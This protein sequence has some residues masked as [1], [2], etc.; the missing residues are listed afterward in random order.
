MFESPFKKLAVIM[1]REPVP[2]KVKTRLSPPLSHQEAAELYRCFLQDRLLAL[3]ALKDAD[4][5]VAY[6]PSSARKDVSDFC[7]EGFSLF[8][9]NGR[10]LGEKMCHIFREKLSEGYAAVSVTGSDSP[11]LPNRLIQASFDLLLVKGADLVLGPAPDGGYYLIGAKKNYP[12]LFSDI[13][14][15]TGKV[16]AE[17]LEKAA[18]LGLKTELLPFWNDLD[19]FQDLVRYHQNYLHR[20]FDENGPGKITYT[21]LAN[22]IFHQP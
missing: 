11:D 1:A 16:L 8:C 2:G 4:I 9:Q 5:A 7:P 17:T 18:Y 15:S 19:T 6:T 14:W 20:K 13:P 21:Y 3:G 10:G 12:E 22:Y